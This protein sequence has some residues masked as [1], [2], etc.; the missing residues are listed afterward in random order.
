MGKLPSY[1]INLC[2]AIVS[3]NHLLWTQSSIIHQQM[4]L[5]LGVK[6]P[7]KDICKLTEAK[8][9]IFSQNDKISITYIRLLV[10]ELGSIRIPARILSGL[11]SSDNGVI[12]LRF[13]NM[14]L[15]LRGEI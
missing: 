11:A 1:K 6:G 4:D 9:Y 5:D 3:V 2:I 15:S 10:L 12:A 7:K 8:L 13:K 14:I